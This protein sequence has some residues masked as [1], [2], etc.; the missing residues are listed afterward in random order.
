[1]VCAKVNLVLI[2]SSD[3]Q[4]FAGH[5]LEMTCWAY[6]AATSLLVRTV[7]AAGVLH[8][9][10]LLCMLGV[11]HTKFSTILSYPMSRHV[12]L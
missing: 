5:I 7:V 10:N 3:F 12:N 1:L 11:A 8:M 6:S 2:N 9:L 4:Q